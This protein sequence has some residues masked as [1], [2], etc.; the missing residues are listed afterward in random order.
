MADRAPWS[1]GVL[2]LGFVIASLAALVAVP[3]YFGQ[4]VAEVQDRIAQV[5]EPAA[6]E[7]SELR[8]LKARQMARVE[9]FMV[10]GDRAL[11]AEYNRFIDEEDQAITRL[12]ELARRVDELTAEESG[13]CVQ[14]P[15]AFQRVSRL[16]VASVDWRFLIE[17]M[18][19]PPPDVPVEPRLDPA[20]QARIYALFDELQRGARELD[21]VIE[22]E[23]EEAR[24][25]MAYLLTL[26]SRI[27]GGLAALAFLATLIVG[28]VAYRYRDLTLEREQRRREAVQARREVDALLEA[29]GDGVLG[30]DLAGKCTSLNRAGEKLLGYTQE[31]IVGRDVHATLFH[32]RPDGE[33][34][35]REESELVRAIKEGRSL[36]S[37]EDAI[38]W[39]RKRRYFPARWSLRPMVDGLELRGAVLT[40]TDMTETLERQAALER[41]V[42]QREDV[43]SIVSHDL[44]NPL[45]VALAAAELLIDLP[46]D[47]EQRR[48]Q[49]EI[50]RRS[51][52]RM[53]RLIEDLLD[54]SRIEADGLLVRL[55]R[56]ELQPIL[57][58]AAELHQE[59]ARAK[60]LTLEI[61]PP[62]GSTEARIDADR[63][64]QALS[65]LLDN[66]IRL[67]PEG[68]RVTLAA[69][70]DGDHVLLSVADTGPGVAP[71][72]MDTLFDRFAQ[73]EGS[74]RGAAGLGLTIVRGVA[75]AHGGRV[76]VSTEL[77]EGSEFV[78]R[79]PK[80]GPERP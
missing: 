36:E 65:N 50:I 33:P 54:V 44:R 1:R 67:T 12:R 23:V 5:L 53:Q 77:G 51:G 49:A 61:S 22:T 42:R 57:E 55:S 52:K 47:E 9:R 14:N 11:R 64:L 29:T 10:T 6:R 38:I 62:D 69:Q 72:L 78:M 17:Q 74:D 66:A 27:T 80:E 13:D 45:G 24:G 8:L 48:R 37:G 43:V 26:Q 18:F 32:T 35:P 4:R 19:A 73:S 68:G 60:G 46:L 70:E 71:E 58:E 3:A 56:E 75:V 39:H 40:F 79:L 20:H 21:Q 15:C 63:I 59:Q 76:T 30:I 41:A 2:A 7:S 28:R 16:G 31:E 34:W 25:R